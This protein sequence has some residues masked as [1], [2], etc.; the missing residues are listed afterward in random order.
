MDS[1]ETLRN[2]HIRKARRQEQQA[3]EWRESYESMLW[4]STNSTPT[5]LLSCCKTEQPESFLL[6]ESV[7]TYMDELW[8]KEHGR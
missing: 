3:R 1:I 8:E 4:I 6:M 7:D 2:F 5:F